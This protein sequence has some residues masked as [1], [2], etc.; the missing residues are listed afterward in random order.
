M[1]FDVMMNL[2]AHKERKHGTRNTPKNCDYCMC[3][4]D[5]ESQLSKHILKLH[6]GFNPQG[7]KKCANYSEED[8]LRQLNDFTDEEIL[9]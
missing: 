2:K 6:L 7:C 8:F 9:D 4:F 5:S 1:K 3:I